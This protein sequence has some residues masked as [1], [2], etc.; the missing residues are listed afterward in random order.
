MIA[1]SKIDAL[2]TVGPL[3]RHM[4]QQ[5]KKTNRQLKVFIYNDVES[6][7]KQLMKIF[8]KGDVVLIKGSRGMRME[9]IVE[10]LRG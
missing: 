5:V 1:R 9:R 6:A 4:A 7:T 2:I 8:D 10:R 3:A